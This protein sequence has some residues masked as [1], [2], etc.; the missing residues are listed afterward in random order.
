MMTRAMMKVLSSMIGLFAV[1]CCGPGGAG[2]APSTEPIALPVAHNAS[3]MP[4]RAFS[5]PGPGYGEQLEAGASPLTDAEAVA[6]FD[7]E[8]ISTEASMSLAL[9]EVRGDGVK[10]WGR[11]V[12][13]LQAGAPADEQRKGLLLPALYDA[14]LT[15]ADDMK[16]WAARGCA[17]WALEGEEPEFQGRLL[18]AAEPG[19]PMDTVTAVVYTAGQAQFSQV[20]FWVEDSESTDTGA[21][22]P[23]LGQGADPWPMVTLDGSALQVSAGESHVTLPCVGGRC[24]RVDDHD[25]AGLEA[26]L[27]SVS[28]S[29]DSALMIGLPG[30]APFAA[31]VRAADIARGLSEPRWPVLVQPVEDAGVT[32]GVED[33]AASPRSVVVGDRVAVLRAL[34]PQIVLP[35]IGALELPDHVSSVE[36]TMTFLTE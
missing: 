20:A 8:D 35:V 31:W 6:C 26:A 15:P 36:V 12:M 25:W 32:L 14:L 23:I 29:D 22:W 3:S 1:G 4:L 5:F 27:G 34:Q 16:T 24:T 18:V 11:D 7:G 28:G 19:V 21:S 17:P 13:A 30:S 33:P 10:A 2:A 9:V